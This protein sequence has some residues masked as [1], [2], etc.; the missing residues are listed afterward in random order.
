MNVL[1]Y[2]IKIWTDF[3]PLCH[4]SRVWQ[5]DRR[6]DGETDARP[7]TMHLVVWG[8]FP[9]SHLNPPLGDWWQL[10]GAG[11]HNCYACLWTTRTR[12][13]LGLAYFKENLQWKYQLKGSV[14]KTVSGDTSNLCSENCTANFDTSRRL[15]WGQGPNLCQKSKYTF[16]LI[17][18][19]ACSKAL[20]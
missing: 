16:S 9:Y 17:E 20:L 11:C 7:Q 13:W 19:A 15:C 5:T 10:G 2:G 8:H 1:S 6:T 12:C 4:N 18:R 3:F 14:F